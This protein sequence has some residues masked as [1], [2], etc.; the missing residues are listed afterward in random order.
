MRRAGVILAL[1]LVAACLIATVWHDQSRVAQRHAEAMRVFDVL[2]EESTTLLA[3]LVKSHERDCSLEALMHFNTHMLQSRYIREIGVLDENRQLICTTSLGRLPQPIKDGYPAHIT[4]SG[5]E[6]LNNVQLAMADAAFLA[7]IIQRPPFNVV[8]SRYATG[9]I[10]ASADIVWLRTVNGLVPL[11]VSP[12]ED[13]LALRERAT[14]QTG[15]AFSLQGFGYEVISAGSDHELVL[16]TRRSVGAVLRENSALLAFLLAA[17]LLIAALVVSAINPYVM[18]LSKLRNRIGFLCDEAHLA[19]VYQPIFDLATL[20]PVGCEVLTRLR[21]G[22]RFWMPDA[23]IP[24]VQ[25]AGLESQFDQAVVA[26][27]IRE[28]GDGLPHSD[29][30]FFIALN[31]FPKSLLP[32]KLI[33]VL[34]QAIQASARQDI[35]VCL[36]ITEH[37]LSSELFTEVQEMKAQGFLIAV[38]DFGTGYSNLKTVKSL[39]P[40][41]LKIDRSFVFELEDASLR[42]NLIPEIVNIAKAI[43]AL[44]VAEGIE[45]P[46][47]A[48]VLAAAGVDYGQGYALARPMRLQEFIDFMAEYR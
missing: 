27:A 29:D 1:V 36:E 3:H 8:L 13:V 38:D 15:P 31:C 17:S 47:H 37:S 41:I 48:S 23:V 7:V 9:D 16:Q 12:S 34:A 18:R 20:R 28:L 32:G 24:A 5:L 33:P 10:Y 21:E 22:A 6:L 30:E 19:L 43:G 45:K 46:E 25:E 14:A 42:S 35:Q 40:H 2:T 44:T 11:N 26:K 4:R 39:S